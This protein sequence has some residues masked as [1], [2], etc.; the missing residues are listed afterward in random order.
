MTRPMLWIRATLR[1]RRHHR[2]FRIGP[3]V[4]DDAQVTWLEQ[5]VAGI[6]ALEGPPAPS[7]ADENTSAPPP[8][9]DGKVLADAATNLWNA[10]KKLERAEGRESRQA[11]RYLSNTRDALSAAGLVIQD[12][13]G[14][15]FHHGQ[16]LEAVHIEPVPG[17]DSEIVR[18]T[19][20]PSV[21][22][23]NHRIQMGQVHVDV[24]AAR[25]PGG[26]ENHA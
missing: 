4:W 8:E 20:R 11:R 25:G 1:Q 6:A 24:P 21:Y 16:S 14:A 19:V 17:L 15:P 23:R 5:V 10:G 12:H 18:R 7:T 13:D 3:P 26:E 9:L 22:F 2:A